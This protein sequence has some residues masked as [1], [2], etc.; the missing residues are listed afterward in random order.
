MKVLLANLRLTC[1]GGQQFI[2]SGKA[3][4]RLVKAVVELSSLALTT[5]F[6]SEI[7]IDVLDTRNNK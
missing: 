1:L 6:V 7:A 4:N 5:D 3:L 2:S